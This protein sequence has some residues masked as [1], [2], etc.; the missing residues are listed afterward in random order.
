M[1]EY[2]RVSTVLGD[3]AG[4]GMLVMVLALVAGALVFALWLVK[5]L[6]QPRH[7]RQFHNLSRN[8]RGRR[9]MARSTR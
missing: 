6:M 1:N 2:E 7:E 3:I 5:G 4:F 9:A 8:T